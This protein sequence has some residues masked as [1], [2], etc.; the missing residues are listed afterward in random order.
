MSSLLSRNHTNHL[1][2]FTEM[3]LV[4]RA[5]MEILGLILG[6]EIL[7]GA[8][9]LAESLRPF[10]AFISEGKIDDGYAIDRLI[11]PDVKPSVKSSSFGRFV[12]H[13]TVNYRTQRG[14]RS[15]WDRLMPDL[16]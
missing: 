3:L 12:P 2:L 7:G 16:M 9:I 11:N 5:G 14:P 1:H 4:L 8:K 6:S 13:W 15:N 10:C